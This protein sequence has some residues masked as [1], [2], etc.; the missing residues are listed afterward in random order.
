MDIE[1]DI[2]GIRYSRFIMKIEDNFLVKAVVLNLR[3]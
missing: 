2:L 1:Y 3:G